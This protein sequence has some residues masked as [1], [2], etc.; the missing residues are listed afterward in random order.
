MIENTLVPEITVDQA[1]VISFNGKTLQPNQLAAAV[2]DAGFVNTQEIN[3]LIPD[4]PDRALMQTITGELL[5][6]GYTRTIFLKNRKATSALGK[7]R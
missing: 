7:P 5:R 1:G 4:K 3:I 6:G 2:R